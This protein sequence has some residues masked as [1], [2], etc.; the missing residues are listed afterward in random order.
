MNTAMYEHPLTLPQLETIQKFWN[1]KRRPMDPNGVVIVPPRVKVLA[2]GEV[3]LGALAPIDQIVAS[4]MQALQPCPENTQNRN[5]GDD[6][7]S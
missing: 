5:P 7:D 1:G 6:K 3:G 4:V 2:C